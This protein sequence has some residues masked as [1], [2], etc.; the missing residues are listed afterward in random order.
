[1]QLASTQNQDPA[2]THGAGAGR[3]FD[4]LQQRE[5]EQENLHGYVILDRDGNRPKPNRLFRYFKDIV[6]AAKLK[7]RED[8]RFYS[9]WYSC[10]AWLASQSVSEQ[11]IQEILDHASSATTQIYSHVAGDAMVDAMERTFGSRKS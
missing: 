5:G 11:I 7:D 3:A 4:V 1:M 6:R 9:L 2:E 10:G 8:L